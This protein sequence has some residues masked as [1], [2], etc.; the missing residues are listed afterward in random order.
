MNTRI[1][2]LTDGTAGRV[3]AYLL[4]DVDGLT[5]IDTLSA[6]DGSEVLRALAQNDSR[7]A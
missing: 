5:L 4:E 2:A 7:S 1:H 3:H 6:D